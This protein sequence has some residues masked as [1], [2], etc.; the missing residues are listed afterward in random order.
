MTRA[1]GV[2]GRGV[3]ALQDIAEGEVI[4]EYTGQ[5]ISWQEAQDATHTTRN[6]QSHFISTSMKTA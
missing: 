5:V 4:I 2:H 1:L 6:N 3:F